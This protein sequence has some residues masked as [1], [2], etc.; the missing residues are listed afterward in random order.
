MAEI[1]PLDPWEQGMEQPRVVVNAAF[2]RIEALSVG[3]IDI[4][5]T[6]PASPD[7]GDCYIL[8]PAPTGAIWG[9]YAEH[10]I[11]LFRGDAWRI[12]TPTFGL[13]K[14]VDAALMVFDGANWVSAES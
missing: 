5:S 14:W 8:G 13:L 12:F 9:D 7:E 6:Q 10:D 4:E 3:A 11:A 1:F 2:L